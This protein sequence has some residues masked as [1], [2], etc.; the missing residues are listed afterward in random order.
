M[1]NLI[2]WVGQ[3]TGRLVGLEMLPKRGNLIYWRCQCDCGNIVEVSAHNLN[4][5]DTKSCGCL[6]SDRA[7]TQAKKMGTKFGGVNKLPNSQGAINHIFEKYKRS[8]DRRDILFKLSKDQFSKLI[9]G[10]CHYCGAKPT[11]VWRKKD[12]YDTYTYTGIDRKI[13]EEG[14]TET[15]S[16]SCCWNCNRAKGTS[17]EEDFLKHISKIFNFQ[18]TLTQSI[19]AV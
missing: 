8:A 11:Q 10:D 12:S 1:P 18:E 6:K 14:Y 16:V 4:C 13:N 3:R 9:Q 17:S 5:G 7:S 15:N 19:V 2:N